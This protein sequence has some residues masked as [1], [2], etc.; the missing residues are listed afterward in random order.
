MTLV[1]FKN[2]RPLSNLMTSNFFDAADFFGRDLLDVGLFDDKFWNGKTTEPAMN[3]L[4]TDTDFEIELVAPG[5][6][7]KDFEVSID[8]GYLNISAEKSTSKEEEEKNYTRKEFSYNSF[9]RS[10][11]LPDNIIEEDVKAKYK[12][13]IL[14]FKLV[15]KEEEKK[16][17][18]KMIEVS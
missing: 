7:K 11:L 13:G 18:P 16:R 15:K 2:R 1:K 5:F 6:S 9:D 4:E 12:D 14:R 8:N 3:I 10:L 17:M